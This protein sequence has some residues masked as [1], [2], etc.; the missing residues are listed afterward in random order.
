METW[1]DKKILI[2]DDSQ[3]VREDLADLYSELGL[4]VIGGAADGVSAIEQVEKLD[5]DLVSLDIIMPEMD[6]IECYQKLVERFPLV[7]IL[8]VTAL[9]H[10]PR[11]LSQFS[12]LINPELYLPKP[13]EKEI[14]VAKLS[15]L[16]GGN[17][18]E[19]QNSESDS[20]EV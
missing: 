3:L 13:P 9:A 10:E 14:L 4:K 12:G 18:M 2:V 20:L 19:T 7:K 16:F 5:P 11:V 8:M 17:G 15:M 6:G 1:Q